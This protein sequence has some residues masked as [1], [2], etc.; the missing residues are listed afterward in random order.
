MNSKWS[1]NSVKSLAKT[2][3]TKS[4]FKILHGGAYSA[5]K[6]YGWFKEITLHMKTFQE[7]QTKWTYQ[8]LEELTKTC[9]TKK[10]FSEKYNGAY[11]MALK[12]GWWDNLTSHMKPLNSKLHRDLYF[13][14]NFTSKI[15]YIGIG[16]NAHKRYK[17]HHKKGTDKVKK[18]LKC[19]HKFTIIQSHITTEKA[20]ELEKFFI[21]YFREKSWHVLNKHVGGSIGNPFEVM[22]TKEKVHEKAKL[23]T[24]CL[25]FYSAFPGAY[26]AAQ[27]KGWLPE[28]TSHIKKTNLAKKY[29]VNNKE[30]TI[31]EIASKYGFERKTIRSRV[32]K[33]K[34]GLDLIKPLKINQYG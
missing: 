32:A 28:V 7:Q 4:E 22:W 9:K 30:L 23:F 26:D 24:K 5:A 14:F 3:K 16:C 1:L 12:K 8:V 10:E 21:K 2:C 20:I 13:I 11:Q 34:R 27:R 19:K 6:R 17:Q 25:D 33:G 18:L 15:I 29:K 31:S